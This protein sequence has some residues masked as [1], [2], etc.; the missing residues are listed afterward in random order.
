VPT[1]SRPSSNFPRSGAFLVPD[2]VREKAL[3]AGAERWLEGLPQL[4]ASL[5][6]EWSLTL[7]EPYLGGTE[8]YVARATCADGSPAVLKALVA[9]GGGQAAREI[10]VLEL[11]GGEGCVRLLRSDPVREVLL[12]EQLGPSLFDLGLP[13]RRRQEILVEAARRVWRRAPGAP[14]P[15]GAHHAHGLGDDAIRAWEEL[16]RPCDERAIVHAV[17]C[18]RRR[19]VEHDEARAVLVHGDVHQWNALQAPAGGWK[20]IDPDGLLA[21]PEL[22]LGILMREDPEPLLA[23]ESAR[24]RAAWLARKTGLDATAIWEWGV[25][26][27]VTTG[28]LATRIGL[29]PVGRQMLQVAD[30]LAGAER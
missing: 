14:L 29:Q 9:R 8:A 12:L 7:G 23:G 15:S 20:L 10:R 27:R 24:G 26:E 4:L 18:A 6:R 30:R 22:D 1:W 13:A 5:E 25:V 21:E 28:L 19:E 2:V 17:T 3:A 11:A 16:G